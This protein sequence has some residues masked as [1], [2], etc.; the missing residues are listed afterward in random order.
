MRIVTLHG[1]KANEMNELKLQKKLE[2]RTHIEEYSCKR[3]KQ[4]G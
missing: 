4:K 2:A 3:C 1:A